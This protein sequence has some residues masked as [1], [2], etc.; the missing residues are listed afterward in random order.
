MAK[1]PTP[2]SGQALP[3]YSV[4]SVRNDEALCCLK[5]EWNRLSYSTVSAN[6]FMTYA[7]YEAWLR[8]SNS[9]NPAVGLAPHALAIRQAGSLVGIVPL[10]RRVT[11]RIFRVRLLEFVSIHSD[12][13]DLVIGEDSQGL[14]KVVV[15]YLARSSQEWDVLNL[16]DLRCTETE[17]KL[18]EGVL[19]EA[20]LS[21]L[22]I[23][24]VERCPFFAIEGDAAVNIKRLSGDARRTIRNRSVRASKEGLT[25]RIIEN[26]ERE[27]HL[28][29]KL[30]A[31]EQ[32]KSQRRDSQPFV[33]S[34]PGVFQ[35]LFDVLGPGGWLYV[36]LLERRDTALAF[37][38][39]FRSGNKL[40][41]YTKAY[42]NSVA[43]LGPGTLL[44]QA[45]LDYGYEKGFREYDFLRGEEPYKLVWS[46]G[47]R[48][49]FRLMI[50]NRR[51]ISRLK[52]YIYHDVKSALRKSNHVSAHDLPP[53]SA[54][55]LTG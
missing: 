3:H 13:N 33:G 19:T 16:R 17:L 44:L 41:D 7:W 21:F 52:K 47:L 23:P 28:L 29:E 50:W 6:A 43:H 8:Q 25:V 22:V 31:L 35:T 27:P 53:F 10:V 9:A 46:T 12:Y 48:R 20:G 14:S 49:R 55:D 32:K 15:E 5:H 34:F 40:W 51:K 37:Q 39:G 42:D 45:I 30:I 24:E 18:L 54:R 4:E 38:F 11:S 2:H 36:A 26:P 1:S